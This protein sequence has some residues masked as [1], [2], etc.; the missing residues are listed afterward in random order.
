MT[1]HQG[2]CLC[3]RLRFGIDRDP[4]WVTMCFC[5]FCQKTTGSAFMIEPIFDVAAFRMITGE[6][7]RYTHLSEGSGK[8]VYIHF[9]GDC[10]SKIN[11][12]FDRWQDRLGVFQGAFDDPGWFPVTPDNSK[13]IFTDHAPRGFVIPPG[14]KT[15][16][17]HAATLE[18]EPLAPVIHHGYHAVTRG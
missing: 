7:A 18:G 13:Y 4:E 10:G 1:D 16:P 17:A 5:R 15:Y 8:D 6:P 12:T 9:C 2:G 14:Y 3:G 11:L